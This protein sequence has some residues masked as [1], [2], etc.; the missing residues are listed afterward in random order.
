MGDE[1]EFCWLSLLALCLPHRLLFVPRPPFLPYFSARPHTY[2]RRHTHRPRPASAKTAYPWREEE[3]EEGRG[4]IELVR[5]SIG[6]G[7]VRLVLDR[8]T[9][10]R[11]QSKLGG[12]QRRG[13]RCHGWSRDGC[14]VAGELCFTG[15]NAD[16]V[17]FASL[18]SSS[19]PPP[20]VRLTPTFDSYSKM[21][22]LF[23]TVSFSLPRPTPVLTVP[24]PCSFDRRKYVDRCD[25]GRSFVEL[26]SCADLAAFNL[27][28]APLRVPPR[29]TYHV[30]HMTSTVTDTEEGGLELTA[31]LPSFPPPR[32]R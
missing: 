29:C 15:R 20:P 28:L 32:H 7:W 11:A 30:H 12:R 6:R 10:R 2:A 1:L 14:S 9:L 24:L 22:S 17:F 5:L 19:P 18:P 8:C 21:V 26:N 3:E 16:L 27:A 13:I 25:D 31:S 4:R 23:S